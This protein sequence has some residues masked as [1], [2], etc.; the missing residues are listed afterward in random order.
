M[1]KEQEAGEKVD[2]RTLSREADLL[3]ALGHPARLCIVRGLWQNG[4]CNVSHMQACLDA[5]QPTISQH[6][7]KL[8]AAGIIEGVRDG[9]EVRYRLTD[10]RVER[11]LACLF[12]SQ[13][14]R[15]AT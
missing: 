5:P 12:P 11:L 1:E 8:R 14:E 13:S 2:P 3:K 10:A 4:S 7:A 15:D 6:L 9:L